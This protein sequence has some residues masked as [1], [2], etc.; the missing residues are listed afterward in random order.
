MW[1]SSEQE[2]LCSMLKDV[3]KAR[4]NIDVVK[5]QKPG[6]VVSR[7]AKEYLYGQSNGLSPHSNVVNFS[8]LSIYLIGGVPQSPQSALSIGADPIKLV[9]INV[10]RDLFHLVLAVSYAKEPDQIIYK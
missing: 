9:P 4:P 3:L 6:G 5:L 8:N 10:N 2:K 7:N 1:R